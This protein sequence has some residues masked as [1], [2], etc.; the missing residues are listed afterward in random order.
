MS[1]LRFLLIFTA[2]SSTFYVYLFCV[3]NY[4]VTLVENS[5]PS[6]I[7]V[8][9]LHFHT[10]VIIAKFDQQFDCHFSLC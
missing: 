7:K 1:F 9:D 8:L 6:V 10:G 4:F 5:L 2:I 3:S